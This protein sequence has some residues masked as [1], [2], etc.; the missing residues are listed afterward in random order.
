[1]LLALAAGAS[2]QDADSPTFRVDSKLVVTSFHAIR[3]GASI[4]GLTAKDIVMLV[5]GH[6]VTP[7]VVEGGMTAR[8]SMPIEI[9]LLFETSWAALAAN[10]GRGPERFQ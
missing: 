2:A 4:D 9:T 7:D 8:R 1:C 3:S 5:D 6:P 10:D